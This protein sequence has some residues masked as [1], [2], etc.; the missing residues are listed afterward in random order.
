MSNSFKVEAMVRGYHRYKE[1][2]DAALGEQLQSERET[3]NHHDIFAVA[4]LKSGVVV[5]HV[6]RK[7]S[8]VVFF[9]FSDMME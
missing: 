3:D 9:C 4:V 1:I 8:S 7:A 6:P 2:W 5:G